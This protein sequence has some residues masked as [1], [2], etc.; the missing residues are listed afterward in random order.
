M[1]K[2]YDAL[3]EL[4]AESLLFTFISAGIF[5]FF[6]VLYLVLV[7]M[8]YGIALLFLIVPMC[9]LIKRR[10]DT[11]EAAQLKNWLNEQGF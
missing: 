9:F 5:A 11:N 7:V 4:M 1:K 8:T 2:Y 10:A 3:L 6:G